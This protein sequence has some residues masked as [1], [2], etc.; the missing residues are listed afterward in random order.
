[1]VEVENKGVRLPDC[2]MGRKF[3]L[4]SLKNS[5]SVMESSGSE[6]GEVTAGRV[7]LYGYNCGQGRCQEGNVYVDDKPVCDDEWD[8]TDAE[9]VCKELGFYGGRATQNSYFGR[10]NL[11]RQSSWDQ[12]KCT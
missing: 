8:D 10:V 9:V 5:G 7:K 2:I 12:V 4:V 1:M 11:E 6:E 3:Q